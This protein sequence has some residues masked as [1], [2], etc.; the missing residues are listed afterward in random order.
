[1]RFPL[2]ALLAALAVFAT[3]CGSATA[4]VQ[5]DPAAGGDIAGAC[6]EGA[7]DCQD[8]G[9]QP[10]GD[11][12]HCLPD[13]VDCDDP[14]HAGDEPII[15][16]DIHQID[17]APRAQ[18]A[19]PRPELV[20][21]PF[22]MFIQEAV[23]SGQDVTLIWSGGREDCFAL[24]DVTVTETDTEVV[25]TIR[26]G[27]RS[28]APEECTMEAPLYATA[29]ALDQPLGARALLDGSRLVPDDAQS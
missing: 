5:V 23:V 17:Q 6:L 19:T 22:A 29:I 16:P 2:P 20:P 9:E 24:A 10:V 18:E 7:E 28:D 26:A 25:V 1:M 3:A 11:D 21:E 14:P 27:A 12:A 8:T 4:D 15:A 13:A